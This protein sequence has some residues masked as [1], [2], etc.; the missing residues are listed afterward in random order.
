MRIT[1]KALVCSAALALT[2]GLLPGTAQAAVSAA[3]PK[4]L[5]NNALYKSGK[6]PAKK[7]TETHWERGDMAAAR[8]YLEVVMGCL[9][10]S[11]KAHFKKAGMKFRAPD[12]EVVNNIGDPIGACGKFP[13]PGVLAL[14][15][16]DNENFYMLVDGDAL[17]D[18]TSMI[19]LGVMAHEYGHHIQQITGIIPVYDRMKF[20]S[21][22]AHYAMHRRIELQADCLA[23]AFIGSVWSTLGRTKAEFKDLTEHELGGTTDGIQGGGDSPD[24]E[25]TSPTHGK[26]TNQRYWLTRGFSGKGPQVCNTFTA[27]AKRTA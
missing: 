3:P 13:G 11:W 17:D 16:P 21:D 4:T 15:C 20:K 10:T 12:F 24:L 26:P 27:S 18:P 7:C 8:E 23:G 9:N 6:L 1:L 2:A 25:I 22:D 5:A 19:H 14:Y